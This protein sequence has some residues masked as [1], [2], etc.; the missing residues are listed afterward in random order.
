[1]S[2]Q[3]GYFGQTEEL[4]PTGHKFYNFIAHLENPIPFTPQHSLQ[5]VQSETFTLFGK[6]D[7]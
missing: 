7:V 3:Q 5:G 1:M 4:W 2:K 6:R